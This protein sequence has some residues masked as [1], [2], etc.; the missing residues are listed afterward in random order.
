[1]GAPF[2]SRRY[3]PELVSLMSAALDAAWA[4]FDPP[5]RHENLARAILASAIVEAVGVGMREPGDLAQ[6]ATIALS[7]A[8]KVDPDNLDGQA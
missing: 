6:R 7:V 1:M 5:P 3:G 2:A 4:N 8:I